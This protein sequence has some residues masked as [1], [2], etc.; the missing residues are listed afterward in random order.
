MSGIAAGY[1]I[2]I[3]TVKRCQHVCDNQE[4]GL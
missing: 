2:T 3:Q 1:T 4:T